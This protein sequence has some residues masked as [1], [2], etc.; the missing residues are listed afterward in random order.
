MSYPS[1]GLLTRE[2]QELLV[3][4]DSQDLEDLL[5]CKDPLVLQASRER[6]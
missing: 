4:L 2:T 1:L 5:D 6:R 3:E